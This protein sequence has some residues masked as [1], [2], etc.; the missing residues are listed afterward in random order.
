MG[1]ELDDDWAVDTD[2]VR[3]STVDDI[4]SVDEDAE[5]NSADD[6]SVVSDTDA[7]EKSAKDAKKMKKMEKLK[8]K[9]QLK[10]LQMSDFSTDEDT[11]DKKCLTVS[12]MREVLLDSLPF[13]HD[14]QREAILTSPIVELVGMNKALEDKPVF[15]QSIM[16]GIA[17]YKKIIV[18]NSMKDKNEL[19]S[20]I[21]VILCSSA[22][23]ATKIIKDLSKCLKCRVAK[24]FAKHLKVHEQIELLSKE[25][26]P[27]AVATPNRFLKLI[28]L[29]AVSLNS[30]ALVLVDGTEDT[31]KFTISTL[32]GVKE[33]F[34]KLLC[35]HILAAK[36]RLSIVKETMNSH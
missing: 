34:Y 33:D 1:D 27:V 16:N 28:E 12:D 22:I 5:S 4:D 19:G 14:S 17:S 29:G 24:L 15:V 10:R 6:I 18:K 2:L 30:T 7:K 26:Y 20:S 13:E 3:S 25:Y 9:K 31:K 23:R 35:E 11:T 21:V 36:I 32:N 8:E